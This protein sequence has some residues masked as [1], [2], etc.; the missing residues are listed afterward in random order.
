MFLDPQRTLTTC[1][2]ET[3]DDCPVRDYVQ[4]HFTSGDLA[5]FLA[6]SL[7]SLALGGV[8]L[9]LHRPVWLLTWL[10]LALGFFALL[11]V[12]VMCTHCPHYAQPS[13]IL[14]CWANY[15][16][17]K[18]WRFRPGPMST[19]EKA[20]FWA[21]LAVVWGLPGVGIALGSRWYLLATY[22]VAS[23]GAFAA[24]RVGFCARCMNFA[25]PLN[26]VGQA[27]REAFFRRNPWVAKAWDPE[28][29]TS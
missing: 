7:P 23:T 2:A 18:L 21:G 17:P 28:E 13:K 1:D 8:G 22:L 10:G 12:R 14:R 11:E 19:T 15:G 5:R 16:A 4:C 6:I 25:C 26:R 20:L 3:C 29:K 24:L 27:G 9:F